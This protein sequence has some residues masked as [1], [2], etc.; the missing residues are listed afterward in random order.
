MSTR[1]LGEEELLSWIDGGVAPNRAEGLEAHVAGC[2]RCRDA[3]EEIRTFA[4][5]LAA[6][7]EHDADAHVAAVMARLDE[8]RPIA[9][10]SPASWRRGASVASALALAAG[11]ALFA[12]HR[13]GDEG[14][15]A[16]RGAAAAPSLARDVGITVYTG[17]DALEP[18]APGARLDAGA[19]LTAAYTN[20][21]PRPVRLLL[22][23]VDG[24]GTLHW[25]YPAWVD[26]ATD[27]S[28]VVLER[29]ERPK[30][31]PTSV[32]L[33]SPAAGTLRVVAIVT[34]AEL[35]VSDVERLSA[36][37]L[38]RDALRRRFPDAMITELPIEIP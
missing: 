35:H 15:F 34:E 4:S 5:D 2:K 13:R 23:G 31:I 18:L 32:V 37:E 36:A 29:A 25:L 38:T 24:R 11:V 7:V 30:P 3:L 22:V 28:A 19:A 10:R 21:H 1:C 33:D 26:P 16:A 20:V 6:P 14:H 9:K 27:P 17:T 12:A 8:P